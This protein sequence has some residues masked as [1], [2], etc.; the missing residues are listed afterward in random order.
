MLRD[1]LP[2]PPTPLAS[3]GTAFVEGHDI[4]REMP[5]IYSLMGVCPQVRGGVCKRGWWLAPWTRRVRMLRRVHTLPRLLIGSRHRCPPQHPNQAASISIPTPPRQD[6]LLWERLSAREHLTFYGRLKNLRG[7]QLKAAVD[8]ALRSVNLYHGGVGDKQV[9]LCMCIA[10]GRKAGAA[11]HSC[12]AVQQRHE[13]GTLMCWPLHRRALSMSLCWVC[14]APAHAQPSR[15]RP[16]PPA[17]T[18]RCA[19][20]AAA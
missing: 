7:E 13:L 20:T 10:A 16:C 1:A 18:L 19:S 15:S 11:G 14:S 12:S 6:N 8:D 17:P 9:R 5:A 4:R 2:P 3:P